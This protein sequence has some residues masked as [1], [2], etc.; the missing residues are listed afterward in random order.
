MRQRPLEDDQETILAEPTVRKR[1]EVPVPTFEELVVRPRAD[2]LRETE[3]PD[4]AKDIVKTM[5]QM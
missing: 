3:K 2:I 1:L 5:A 4:L